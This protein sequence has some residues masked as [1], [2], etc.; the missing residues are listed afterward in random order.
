ME[1]KVRT[2]NTN[3]DF[4]HLVTHLDK[5]LALRDGEDHAF[6]AQFNKPDFLSNVVVYYKNNIAAGCGAFKAFD[7]KT[8]EIKRMFVL[9]D[10]RNN[11]IATAILKELEKWALELGYTTCILET[12]IKQPEAIHLYTKNQYVR[13]PNYGQY[14]NVKESVC[15]KKL[16]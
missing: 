10:Y 11:H 14:E 16:L 2:N 1:H 9:A 12:G 7:N 13:I 15:M 8:V 4:L 5:E 3:K 6:Y